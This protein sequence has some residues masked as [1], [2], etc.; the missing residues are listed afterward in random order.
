MSTTT[1]GPPTFT[2]NATV[3]IAVDHLPVNFNPW[4]VAGS[5]QVTQMVMQTVWPSV[6]VQNSTLGVQVCTVITGNCPSSLLVSAEPISLDPMTVVYQIAANAKWSDGVEVTGLDFAYLRNEVLAEASSLP[7]SA[8]VVGYEDIRSLVTSQDG[9]TV[10]VVFTKPYEDWQGLFST[11]IPAHIALA[12]GFSS[13]FSGSNLSNLL[14]AGP[15]RITHVIPGREVVLGRN[16][17]YWGSPAHI[18]RIIF[19]VEPNEAATIKALQEGKVT[20]AQLPPSQLVRNTIAT[21]TSLLSTT[22]YTP[23]LWQLAFNLNDSIVGAL[24]V[25]QAITEALD[26][27]QLVAD[28]IGQQTVVT[29]EASNRLFG[30]GIPG[31]VANDARYLAVDDVDAEAALVAA[32]YSYGASGLAHTA[33]GTQLMLHL[34]GPSGS[35]LVNSVEAEIQAELLQVGIEVVVTNEPLATLVGTT[36]PNGGFQMAI[37]PFATNA[38]LSTSQALYVPAADVAPFAAPTIPAGTTPQVIAATNTSDAAAAAV[39]S[40]VVSRDIFGLNDPV[41]QPLFVQAATALS[42]AAANDLYNAIDIQLWQ[43][44]PSV[45]LFQMPV[46]TIYNNSLSGLTPVQ[47]WASF[48]FD[49]QTWNWTLNP[50]PTNTTT[51]IPAAP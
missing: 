36:L 47:T 16:P 14:S 30:V 39:A 41:L 5:N 51:T 23:Q 13:A 24:G 22:S 49:A 20:I 6:S 38:Y 9:K 1:T 21:S 32:G 12:R 8:P 45:P 11:L 3:T 34:V 4:T 43:D 40:S 50:P 7:S 29:G 19:R 48:M 42:P 10:T 2:N 27:P 15:Y 33:A 35:P 46:T 37:A 28:T 17:R 31:G 44:L 26:R 25:R 18:A